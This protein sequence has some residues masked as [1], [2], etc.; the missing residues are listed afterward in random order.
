M[1]AK[2]STQHKLWFRLAPAATMSMNQEKAIEYMSNREFGLEDSQVSK[3]SHDDNPVVV[4][5]NKSR[6]R[7]NTK[8]GFRFLM[9]L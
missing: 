5:V 9:L 2:Q 8:V 3:T 6:H 1:K 4:G 7:R